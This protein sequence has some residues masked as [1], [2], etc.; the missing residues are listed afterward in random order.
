MPLTCCGLCCWMARAMSTPVMPKTMPRAAMPKRL[1]P[2]S[3][4]RVEDDRRPSES[5]LLSFGLHR[6]VDLVAAVAD[7]CGGDD[8]QRHA[9]AFG[10]EC[11]RRPVRCRLAIVGGLAMTE[12]DLQRRRAEGHLND[13]ERDGVDALGRALCAAPT[14]R[15]LDRFDKAPSGVAEEADRDDDEQRPTKRRVE[16]RAHRAALTLR[17]LL[18]S[19]VVAQ[20]ERGRR[21]EPADCH[22]QDRL[23]DEAEASELFD[24]RR[25][26]VDGVVRGS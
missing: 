4:L 26:F 9:S 5:F 12:R 8:P 23:R 20:V 1:I 13:A 14:F 10:L 22:V 19:D 2:T 11:T 24:P 3:H 18:A 15:I 21:S 16:E 7:E 25:H 17:A 6:F